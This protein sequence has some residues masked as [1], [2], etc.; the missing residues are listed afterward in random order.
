VADHL[1]SRIERISKTYVVTIEIRLL[2]PGDDGVLTRVAPDVFDE[3]V[4]PSWTAEF[5]QD[6]RMHLIVAVDRGTVV[7]FASGVHYLHPD[8]P[9]ELFINEVGV[10]PSH[11]RQGLGQRVVQ[12]L[13]ERGRALGCRLAWV[14]T[15]RTNT[16]AMRLYASLGGNDASEEAQ[17]MFE[18]RLDEA[19]SQPQS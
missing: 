19:S 18:F 11:H 5:L 17:V 14:L 9:P 2:G 3:P 8:K 1:D 7:G 15:S 16:P 13:L 6:P 4:H 12:A 10:A